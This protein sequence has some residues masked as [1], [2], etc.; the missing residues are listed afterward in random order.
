MPHEFI[1][2]VNLH[3]L[4][5][6]WAPA[7]GG[8]EAKAKEFVASVGCEDAVVVLEYGTAN[9]HVHWHYWLKTTKSKVTVISRLKAFVKEDGKVPPSQ[10]FSCK[11]ANQEKL[12]KYFQYLAKGPHAEEGTE[13]V[14]LEDMSGSRLWR[15]MHVVFHKEAKEIAARRVGGVKPSWYEMLAGRVVEKCG[16]VKPTKDD[17]AQVVT[18]WYVRDSK[19][20]FDKFAV[21]R[22][23]WAVFALVNADDAEAAMLEQCMR[24][25]E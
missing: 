17:V 10:W 22:T 15:E 2:H 25:L 13:A 24:M 7:P 6:A 21:T 8:W 14:V 23:V 5:P 16:G 20:G 12:P 1:G 18:Q 4:S 11:V 3:W 9:G 19:K